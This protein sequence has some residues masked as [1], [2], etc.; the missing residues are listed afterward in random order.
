M[1]MQRI[2]ENTYIDD[3]LVTC[4]E[5]QLF[6]DDMREQGK[7]YQPDH[8]TAYQFQEGTA[9]E[10]MLGVRRY[11]AEA[12]CVWLALRENE[13]WKYRLPTLSEAELFPM[14]AK[15]KKTFGYWSDFMFIWSNPVHD[16]SKL[17]TKYNRVENFARFFID[18]ER[19]KFIVFDNAIDSEFAFALERFNSLTNEL[20]IY[21]LL[22]QA[23]EID[24]TKNLTRALDLNIDSIRAYNLHLHL[25]GVLDH[26]KF[27]IQRLRITDLPLLLRRNYI[28]ARRFSFFRSQ[29]IT[30]APELASKINDIFDLVCVRENNLAYSRFDLLNS[31]R[32]MAYKLIRILSQVHDQSIILAIE[33]VLDIYSFQERIAGRSSAYEGIRLVKYREA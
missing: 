22:A 6:I 12:F 27:F 11:D 25:N 2:D 4:A 26:D 10:P 29:N 18:D 14:T 23:T 9:Q 31:A 20:E 28:L 33:I 21:D 1:T 17:V 13:D 15:V 3:S 7:Y 8:W 16:F 5:Y 19:A 32:E 30:H 24:L